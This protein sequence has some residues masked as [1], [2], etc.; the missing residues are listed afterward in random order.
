MKRWMF[1][2]YGVACHLMFLGTYAY[3]A[4][5][6]GGFLAPKTVD[7]AGTVGLLTA[8][9]INLVLLAVFAVQHSL[10]A[11]PGF[12]RVWTRVVPA[13]IERSTYVLLSCLAVIFLFWQW[14]GMNVVVWN[15]DNMM[16]RSMLWG[17]FAIGWLTVPF[18]SMLINHF[19]LFGTRQVWLYLRNQ[20]YQSLPFRTPMF[21]KHVRHPL[22]VGW[23]IALWATP[24]MT[25]GHLLLALGL[26]VYLGLATL[27]EER[28]LMAHFGK[29][30]E[31]YCRRVP[32]FVPRLTAAADTV[33]TIEESKVFT[34]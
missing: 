27:V 29:V 33:T 2:A 21:Y 22:Y 12:K 11:R 15:V 20:P 5:F 8:L 10:M 18:V 30:Y 32:M 1:F 7:S 23:F 25:L 14:Q 19:D 24:T 16:V 6:V 26:T 13:P 17:V 31:D 3:F 28:D 9:T 34:Q 4:A